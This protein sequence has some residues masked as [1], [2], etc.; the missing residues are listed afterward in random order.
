M[1]EYLD[2][3]FPDTDHLRKFPDDANTDNQKDEYYPGRRRSVLS[4]VRPGAYFLAIAI[5]IGLA[6]VIAFC[7]GCKAS[8]P[9]CLYDAKGHV[10]TPCVVT[11]ES[12][13]SEK[14]W[15][16][17]VKA[18]RTRLLNE[19]HKGFDKAVREHRTP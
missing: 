16:A 17:A 8:D 9:P 12:M 5:G 4:Q 1:N 3:M 7:T 11:A 14:R 19:Q 13:E 2:P 6:C 15:Q 18:E 10:S